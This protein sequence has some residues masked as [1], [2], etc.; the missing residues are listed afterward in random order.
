MCHSHSVFNSVPAFL[1]TARSKKPRA[2]EERSLLVGID[3]YILT[4]ID[5]FRSEITILVPVN[6]WLG[7]SPQHANALTCLIRCDV[8]S[9]YHAVTSCQL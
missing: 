9:L 5:T 4:T 8:L 3:T 7:L 6:G 1:M 2:L